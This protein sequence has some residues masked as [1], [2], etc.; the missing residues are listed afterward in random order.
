MTDPFSNAA[1]PERRVDPDGPYSVDGKADRYGRYRLPHPE[2]GRPMPWT[3]AS[4]FAKSC[5]DTYTLSMWSQ[6]MAIK[7]ITM[8]PDLYAATAATSLDERDALN[9]IAETAK[10]VAG[11]KTAAGLGTAL[12]AFTEQVDRGQEPIIPAPWDA[13]VEAYLAAMAGGGITTIPSAI[14][15]IVICTDFAIAGRY[16][17]L[18]WDDGIMRVADLK[19]GRDLEYGWTEIAIQLAIYANAT[20]W[21]DEEAR[22][23][24]DMPEVAKDRAIVMHLPVGQ[25]KCTLYDVDIAAGWRAAQLCADVRAW[26]RQRGLATPRSVA[27]RPVPDDAGPVRTDEDKAD[28]VRTYPAPVEPDHPYSA[29]PPINTREPTGAERIAAAAT[30]AD[31]AAVGSALLADGHLTPELR[32]LGAARRA[33]LLADVAGG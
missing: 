7:G 18:V 28:A 19:T 16:D 24:R 33:A 23:Y 31:L 17:R 27:G 10:E 22:E 5:S 12:H 32:E 6:R 25:A 14:E 26:R 2:S 11:A 4:T 20:F 3:R 13:D 9:K 21:W 30:V 15:R 29:P 8:R 1:P